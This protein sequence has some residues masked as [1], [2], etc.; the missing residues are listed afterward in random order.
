MM[1]NYGVITSGKKKKLVIKNN[2]F[3]DGILIWSFLAELGY[4]HPSE[5]HMN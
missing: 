3:A 2:M 4:C 1:R 5:N